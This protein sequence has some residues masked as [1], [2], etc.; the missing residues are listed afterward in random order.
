M[1][2]SIYMVPIFRHGESTLSRNRKTLGCIHNIS[3]RSLY[4]G[5]QWIRIYPNITLDFGTEWYVPKVYGPL[6]YSEYIQTVLICWDIVN[7]EYI[8]T[9][10]R[11]KMVC[12][13]NIWTVGS[14]CYIQ[15]V[16]IFRGIVDSQ[17]IQTVLTFRKQKD[18]WFVRTISKR[19]LYFGAWWI[20]SISKRCIH[21]ETE[22][23]V[24]QG[25]RAAGL[26]YGGYPNGPFFSILGHRGFIVYPNGLYIS[27]QSHMF[28]KQKDRWCIHTISER[29]LYFGTE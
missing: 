28:R 1:N 2:I 19:C 15:T 21:L 9:M 29:T 25:I 4:F 8:Q 6:V 23:Y 22:W 20:H 18:R 16:L 13:E 7:S 12:P 17:Y 5:S 10:F 11:D 27:G 3:K 24:P 14:C 26:C